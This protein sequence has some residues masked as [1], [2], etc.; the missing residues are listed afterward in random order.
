MRSK[1]L[2]AVD[3]EERVDFARLRADRLAKTQAELNKHEDIGALVLFREINIRYVTGAWS[4]NWPTDKMPFRYTVLLKGQNPVLYGTQHEWQ[5]QEVTNSSPWLGQIKPAI[6]WGRGTVGY[7]ATKVCAEYF[8]SDLKNVLK[9]GNVADL[10]V[11]VDLLDAP[12]VEALNSAGIQFTDAQTLMEEARL[13]KT[14]D[15]IELLRQCGAMITAAFWKVK[16]A[17]RPGLRERELSAI[18]AETL[19][20]M[21][22]EHVFELTVY[23]GPNSNPNFS[24]TADRVID[25]GDMVVMDIMCQHMGYQVPVYRSFVCG[26]KPTQQQKDIFKESRETVY[27][28]INLIKDGVSSLELIENMPTKESLGLTDVQ[29]ADRWFVHGIGMSH[30]G[31]PFISPIKITVPIDN[32][33]ILKENM[34]L[35]P[36][37]WVGSKD[38]T[39]GVL[40]Q[41]PGYVTKTGFELFCKFP[42]DELMG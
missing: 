6:T 2:A 38:G 17:L 5:N 31:M 18:A 23:T 14:E 22:C 41:Q 28:A 13:I 1:G 20:N 37:S 4:G 30:Y 9:E 33:V 42:V 15:E 26:G 39:E 25:Y 36:E 11:G 16:E 12:M 34:C 40:I 8:A 32:P 10:K 35:G 27:R 24:K 3:W 21:G 7:E 19:Y 29:F